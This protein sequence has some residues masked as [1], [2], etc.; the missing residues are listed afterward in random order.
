MSSGKI[1][2]PEQIEL[3]TNNDRF[4]A[5]S[6]VLGDARNYLSALIV[7]DWAE[8][9]RNL[10]ALNIAAAEPAALIADP[11]L[12]LIFKQRIEKINDQLA[13]WEKIRKFS[14]L[15]DE[16]SQE[17]DELTPTLK[18]RRHIIEEH[19]QKEIE[20]MYGN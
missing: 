17:K 6:M 10:E 19:Y 2:W 5:S 8:V 14:L 3:L 20:K 13:D 16:F 18:L 11:K 1:A 9:I 7:P 15:I 12:N 4:I